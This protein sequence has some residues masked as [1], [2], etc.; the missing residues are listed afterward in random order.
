MS[1]ITRILRILFS[2]FHK[3]GKRLYPETD[4]QISQMSERIDLLQ[5]QSEKSV[6]LQQQQFDRIE[7]LI[8]NNETLSENVQNINAMLDGY[9]K[10]IINIQ[11]LNTEMARLV[12]EYDRL[13]F[14]LNRIRKANFGCGADA[15]ISVNAKNAPD[16]GS[17]ASA[18]PSGESYSAID[19]FDFENYFR[20]SRELIKK[21][22]I[23][24]L[25]YFSQ[26][27]KVLD[28]GCGRGEFL[29]IMRDNGILATGVDFYE[30]FVDYCTEKGL[31]AVCMDG[32]AY[33]S[34]E[35]GFDGIFAGQVIEHMTV[36]Q[37]V[38]LI[39]TAYTKLPE[40]GVLIMETPNP[41][42]LSIYV[43]AFY[44]DPSHIKPVHPETM[45]Y[46]LKNSGFRDVDVIY[47]EASRPDITIPPIKGEDEFNHVMCKIQNMLFGSQDYAVVARK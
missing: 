20:G 9:D 4:Q 2:P 34:S 5:K 3:L 43:N 21:R 17:A 31:N 13:S 37:I 15:Q 42:S 7:A 23:E 36:S 38:N 27:R 1:K 30:P 10:V 14:M 35:N 29:E 28:I 19:Y 40:G 44:L 18:D 33:L 41:Q 24:Y 12:S 39:D 22:Q 32:I 26:C 16:V 47:T 6:I 11:N 25:P 46:L 8:R 45:R